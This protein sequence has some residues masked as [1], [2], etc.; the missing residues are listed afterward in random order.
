MNPKIKEALLTVRRN[1]TT[2]ENDPD[3]IAIDEAI[4]LCDEEPTV[5][6]AMLV[7]VVSAWVN[8]NMAVPEPIT[9][10]YKRVVARYGYKAV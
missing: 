9:E 6:M 8:H 5:P 7:E 4:A 2:D 1:W 10:A 3:A